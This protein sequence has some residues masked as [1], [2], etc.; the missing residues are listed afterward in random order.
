LFLFTTGLLLLMQRA[1]RGYYIVLFLAAVGK[2]TALLLP[3][4]HLLGADARPTKSTWLKHAV[5]Q[6]AIV[7]VV[8][9]IIQFVIFAGNPGVGVEIWFSRN[10]AFLGNTALMWLWIGEIGHYSL[11]LP[12]GCNVLFLLGVPLLVWDWAN[13]S[14]MLRRALWVAPFLAVL[15]LVMGQVDE[16]RVYYP[17]VPIL[18]WLGAHTLLQIDQRRGD[19]AADAHSAPANR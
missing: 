13:K 4:I 18:F 11:F 3:I 7:G 17:L 2:E 14:R 16:V 10:V 19:P 9:G 5:A 8:R 15:T 12:T 1:W 6:V